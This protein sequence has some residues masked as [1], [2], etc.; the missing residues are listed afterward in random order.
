MSQRLPMGQTQID[1]A[2]ADHWSAHARQ[3][4]LIDSPLRPHADDIAAMHVLLQEQL[5]QPSPPNELSCGL[6][7]GVTPE[8]TELNANIIAIDRTRAM[9]DMLHSHTRPSQN[10]TSLSRDHAANKTQRSVHGNWLALPFA[11]HSIDFAVGDGSFNLLRYPQDYHA[12]FGQLRG[13]L[14]PGALLV[15]RIFTAPALGE[16]FAAVVV[17]AYAQR[18]G[19]FHAFKW[20]FAMALVEHNRNPNICVADIYREFNA[21]IPDRQT[22]AESSGWP[23]SVIDTIDV[24]RDS[25]AIYSFP[26]AEE[27]S[28]IAARYSEEVSCVTGNYELAE[29]CPIFAQRFRV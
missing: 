13:A 28:V 5:R 2:A 14:K 20:R 17:D 11:L 24:Y 18:I 1:T 8:L 3:W 9:L 21:W 16:T 25:A 29:R 19:S 23:G 7:L 26:T 15:A 10:E 4:S 12:L 22:L 27:W 6:L